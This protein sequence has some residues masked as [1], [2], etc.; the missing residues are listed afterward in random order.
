MK[1][2]SLFLA[3]GLAASAAAAAT[4]ARPSREYTIEQFLATTGISGASFSFDGGRLLFSSNATG[5]YNVQS[6]PTA[7]GWD[8]YH[9]VLAP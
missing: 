9:V 1:P 7:G 6:I 4:Q 8:V 5:I 3:L 2:R